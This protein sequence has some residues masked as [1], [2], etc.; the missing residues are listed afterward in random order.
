MRLSAQMVGRVW[1]EIAR[2]CARDHTPLFQA[3]P[4]FGP[5]ILSLAEQ[6]YVLQDVAAMFG[7]S[8]ERVRQWYHVLGVRAMN[9]RGGTRRGH[10]CASSIR[11]S[12]R[13]WKPR[14]VA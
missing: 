13:K 5:S 2:Q 10:R 1:R 7:V 11:N 9:L 6:G 8:R 3:L 14:G 12:S 4:H